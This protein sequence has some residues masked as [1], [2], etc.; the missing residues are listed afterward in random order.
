MA[1]TDP[2]VDAYIEKAAAFAQPV[3]LHLREVVHAASPEVEETMKWNFPHFTYKGILCSMAAFKQH[4]AFGFWRGD[5]VL[6]GVDV[7][8][9]KAMGQFGR[10]TS[11]T[12]LPPRKEL[13]AY[14]RAAMRLNE[15]GVT[16]P[17]P[18]AA[19]PP[20]QSAI[21]EAF[22]RA[23]EQHP[24]SRAAFAGFSPSQ[25]REYVDWIADAKREDTQARRI[26]TAIEWIAEGKP[27]H[28]KYR[29]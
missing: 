15:A 22:G 13:I 9:N 1:T 4:C 23:L 19:K 7:P 24:A 11:V 18:S 8:A 20:K 29:R 25:R 3:L 28:W 26:N 16:P 5:V 14:V 27:R 6:G 2:R 10:I 21:P 17:R 12:D